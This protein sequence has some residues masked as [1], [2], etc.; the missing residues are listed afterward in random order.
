MQMLINFINGINADRV[1]VKILDNTAPIFAETYQ[2]GANA[3]Y[4]RR[5]AAYAQKDYEDSIKYHWSSC[6]YCPKPYIGDILTEICGKYSINRSDIIYSGKH[7]F[8][9]KTYT[10]DE[11]KELAEH[12][13]AE[14]A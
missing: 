3:S 10:S 5:H 14:V 6:Y 2:Y 8:S 1:E 11:L 12:L 9:G 13:F 4:C 7:I